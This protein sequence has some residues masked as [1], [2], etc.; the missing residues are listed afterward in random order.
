MD[1]KE[2][3]EER[4]RFSKKPG[5]NRAKTGDG[6]VQHVHGHL[7]AVVTHGLN[8]KEERNV[9]TEIRTSSALLHQP[10]CSHSRAAVQC[11]ESAPEESP[12]PSAGGT[13]TTGEARETGAPLIVRGGAAASERGWLKIPISEGSRNTC[14]RGHTPEEQEALPVN[15]QL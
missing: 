6:L 2:E 13:G 15:G 12:S 3:V 8:G 9:L 7:S 14:T 1:F 10:G 11:A 4:H 5:R